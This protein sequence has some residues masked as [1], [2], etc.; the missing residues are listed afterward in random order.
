MYN[1]VKNAG[2]SVPYHPP[3]NP[4]CAE[5]LCTDTLRGLFSGCADF[6]TRAVRVGGRGAVSAD[7]CFFDGL[8]SGAEIAETLLRPLTDPARF[9]DV[10][11][12]AEALAT[13]LG[14]QVYG[15][16]ARECRTADEAAQALLSGCCLLVFDGL[17]RAAAFEA[18][19][20]RQRAITD[21]ASERALKGARDSFVETLRVNTSLLRR[22]LR[23][24]AL[25]LRAVTLGRKSNTRAEIVYVDGVADPGLVEG[26]E[27]RIMRVETDG[28]LTTGEIESCLSD[29]IRSPFPTLLLTERPDRFCLNL[30][31]GRVGLLVDGIPLGWLLPG[32]LSQQLRVPDDVSKHFLPASAMTLLRHLALL[33]ML[34]FP[35]LYAATAMF[36]QEMLPF[37]LL[38]S[39]I[40]SKQSVPFSTALELLGM[41]TAFELLQEAGLRLPKSVGETVSII[42]ALI[43]GQSAVE[44]KVVSPIA[45]IV[46]ATSGIAGYTVPDQDL[47]LALR[48][49]RFALVLAAIAAGMFGIAAALSMLLWH[50]CSLDSFGAAYLA[51]L[52]DGDAR[53]WL[54][55]LLQPPPWRNLLRD[56]R[57]HTPDLRRRR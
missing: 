17:G 40:E 7:C 20:D 38:L 3:R 46:V 30:L 35:A 41:L 12:E 11:S 18:K 54:R 16:S 49:C 24:P 47:A 32:T 51:P 9:G 15:A 8:V 42:G 23:T 21:P 56:R 5:R 57:L 10:K 31:E 33:T 19:T 45:V 22:H 36:H 50:L 53:D 43:V 26:L 2:V 55:A 39:I 13:V 1:D 29:S 44:A 34:L 37:R 6:Q 52:T 25:K 4:D 28:V 48:L 27:S 14:G